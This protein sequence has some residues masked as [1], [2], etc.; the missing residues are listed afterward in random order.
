VNLEQ[1]LVEVLRNTPKQ[2]AGLVVPTANK[3]GFSSQSDVLL[4]PVT[5]VTLVTAEGLIVLHNLI[6][7]DASASNKASK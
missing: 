6:K 3:V 7:R 2:P 1:S 5:P 4:T